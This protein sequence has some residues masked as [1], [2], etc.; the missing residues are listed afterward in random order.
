MDGCT[1]QHGEKAA[2]PVLSLL[3]S[4]GLLQFALASSS[5]CS[6]QYRAKAFEESHGWTFAGSCLVSEPL[7]D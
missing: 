7:T 3:P 5:C 4:V 2:L 1:A 6:Q